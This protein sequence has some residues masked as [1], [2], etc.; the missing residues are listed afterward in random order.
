MGFNT[1]C[2]KAKKERDGAWK[3]H[4]RRG[5]INGYERFKKVRNK[6]LAVRRNAEKHFEKDMARK[7]K[8]NPKLFHSFL[9][10]KMKVKEQV[11]KLLKE[12]GSIAS[13]D[14]EIC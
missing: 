6:Y 5:G 10:S 9:R 1:V 11:I 14:E 2:K 8:D 7:A 13:T 4:R 3:R 12:D